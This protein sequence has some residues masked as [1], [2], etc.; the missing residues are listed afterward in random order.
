MTQSPLLTVYDTIDIETR[1]LENVANF[2][3]FKGKFYIMS[4]FFR[5]LIVITNLL[6]P[7]CHYQI[8]TFVNLPNCRYQI[9]TIV[10]L[11]NWHYQKSAHPVRTKSFLLLSKIALKW[12][13][14]YGDVAFPINTHIQSYPQ[15]TRLQ[16]RLY[17]FLI[18]TIPAGDVFL[19]KILK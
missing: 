4:L 6:I 2:T 5:Y 11:P 8:V 19:F 7:N 9:V 17:C 14:H 3:I 15:R 10:T 18:F 13:K 12:F 1:Y 16:R